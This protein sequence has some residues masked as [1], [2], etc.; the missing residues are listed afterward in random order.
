YATVKDAFMLEEQNRRPRASSSSALSS[1]ATPTTRGMKAN[2][3]M[4]DFCKLK[5][6]L[7]ETCYRY[8]TAQQ[9]AEQSAKEKKK[10]GKPSSY[11]AKQAEVEEPKEDLNV[12]HIAGNAST[13]LDLSNP[14]SA[15]MVN[16]S[17][18]WT[19]DTGAS[20]HMTPHQHWFTSY[21]PLRIPIHLAD[22]QTIYSAGT[23]S[24]RFKPSEKRLPYSLLEFK[25]VLH[26]PDLKS[27][28]FS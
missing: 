2:N 28:L 16:A 14:A 8:R 1:M 22:G 11:V 18:D 5:G 23:G 3:K 17:S 12:A 7:V 21:T 25:N 20:S 19:A 15:L 6:H 10:Q 13:L 27:N 24:V 26:V 4:C 9:Q